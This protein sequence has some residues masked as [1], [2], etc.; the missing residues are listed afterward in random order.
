MCGVGPALPRLTPGMSVYQCR[1]N[2]GRVPRNFGRNV[3]SEGIPVPGNSG[4]SH[5]WQAAGAVSSVT[6][7]LP[8]GLCQGWQEILQIRKEVKKI[9]SQKDSL[10]KDMSNAA[11]SVMSITVSTIRWRTDF[12]ASL[13]WIT[14]WRTFARKN[15]RPKSI[16]NWPKSGSK[17]Q[18]QA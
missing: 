5:P 16:F 1:P 17:R 13:S 6:L 9:F 12:L 18:E 3:V 7:L 4:P 8:W 14:D 15:S 11:I 2:R 10:L